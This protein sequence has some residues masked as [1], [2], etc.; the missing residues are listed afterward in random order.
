[1]I[2]AFSIL[3]VLLMTACG[4]SHKETVENPYSERMK[5]LTQTGV[6]AMVRERWLVAERLFVRA[7]QA[8]QLA[9]DPELTGL[10]WYNLGT[11]YAASGE[12][13]KA[14]QVLI[15]CISVAQRHGLKVTQ[16]RARVALALLYQKTGREAWQPQALDSSMPLD[17]HLSVARLA[18]L[19]KRHEMARREYDYV[20]RKSDS[21]RMTLLYKMDAHMGFALLLIDD[22]Q[23]AEAREHIAAVQRM[24]REI[25]APRQA[26]HALILGA[27]LEN[28][29]AQKLDDLRDAL[30]IYEA[31][32]DLRGQKDA[33]KAL[34][35]IAEQQGDSSRV[36][37]LEKRLQRL[38]L[39]STGSESAES[40]PG[41][42]E[43]EQKDQ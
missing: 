8:A 5:D 19:Q 34:R 12:N 24:S 41:A 30:A 39:E 23:I 3:L 38:E 10:A 1:M 2:R 31:M 33:L 22:D 20:L 35:T 15:R 11:V 21:D 6:D 17:I 36:E 13:E 27:R 40:E 28:D 7:L 14:E 43:P 9:N 16:V 42:S 25:G 32:D 18:Q 29:E 4:G 37:T 26:A